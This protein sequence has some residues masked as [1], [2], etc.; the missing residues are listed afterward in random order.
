[1]KKLL[2]LMAALGLAC[3]LGLPYVAQAAPNAQQARMAACNHDAG[4]RKGDDRKAFMKE[5]LHAKKS[6][7]QQ[8]R[9]KA[10][11]HDAGAR[12]GDDRK[13]FMK[14]CLSGR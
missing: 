7:T 8:E 11:N 13:V 1:M 14:S 9:M 12:K 3:S 6:M 10:C 4:A 5:C 2:P